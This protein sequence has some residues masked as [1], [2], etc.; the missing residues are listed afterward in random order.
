MGSSL[1]VLPTLNIQNS[2]VM[3][4]PAFGETEGVKPEKLVD[5]LLERNCCRFDLVDMDAARN[6]GSNRAL[7]ASLI[8]R[9]RSVNS[10]VCVQVG[11]GIHSSDQ[12]QFFV[13]LGATW[14]VVGTVLHRYPVVVDQLLARFR[15]KLVASLDARNGEVHSSG[16]LASMGVSAAGMALRIRDLGFRRLLFTDMPLDPTS[17]PDFKTAQAICDQARIPMFMG[18]SFR[19]P[20]HLAQAAEV[21]GLQGLLVEAPIL[22]HYPEMIRSTA[23]ACS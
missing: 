1:K 13:D 8:R 4:P 10:K 3:S 22:L 2:L 12:A 14:L 16:G 20:E 6:H 9:I 7:I 11:G 21:R 15:E 5:A 23:Q 18:G 17:Q 19:T